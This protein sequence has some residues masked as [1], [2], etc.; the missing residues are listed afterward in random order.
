MPIEDHLRN[1]LSEVA[2]VAA[3]S[4]QIRRGMANGVAVRRDT[5]PFILVNPRKPSDLTLVIPSETHSLIVSTIHPVTKAQKIFTELAHRKRERKVDTY[6]IA[7]KTLD[8]RTRT[9]VLKK[10]KASLTEEKA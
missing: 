4:G 3:D 6:R 1:T 7:I 5:P 8:S 9:H 10:L 2:I